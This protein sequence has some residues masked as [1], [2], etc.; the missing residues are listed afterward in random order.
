MQ[1]LWGNGRWLPV[2][3]LEEILRLR[4][5][6]AIGNKKFREVLTVLNDP[7]VSWCVAGDEVL[8]GQK[9]QLSAT[10]M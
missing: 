5:K 7:M 6:G 4:I 9:W 2:P 1:E 3:V 10:C 8:L